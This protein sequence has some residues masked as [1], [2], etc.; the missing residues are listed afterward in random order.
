MTIEIHPTARVSPLA[1]IEDS[2]RDARIEVGMLS[3][4]LL[5]LLDLCDATTEGELLDPAEPRRHVMAIDIYIRPHNREADS[6][7]T[8]DHALAELRAYAPGVSRGCYRVVFNTFVQDH[9][10]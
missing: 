9:V 4:S 1:D 7:H 5:A 6:M 3:A 8:H 2:V 10:K